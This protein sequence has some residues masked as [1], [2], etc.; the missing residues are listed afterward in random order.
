L[1]SKLSTSKLEKTKVKVKDV[2]MDL[3]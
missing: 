3:V 1:M 2:V